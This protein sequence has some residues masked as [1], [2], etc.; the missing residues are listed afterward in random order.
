[1][2]RGLQ[3][4]VDFRGQGAGG[5]LRRV[6]ICLFLSMSPGLVRCLHPD[7]KRRRPV[8]WKLAN[9]LYSLDEN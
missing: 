7:R 9:I 2:T 4:V 8:G 6:S 3:W 1:M 5:L